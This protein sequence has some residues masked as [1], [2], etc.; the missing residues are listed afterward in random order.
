MKRLFEVEIRAFVAAENIDEAESVEIHRSGAEVY[1]VEIYD[2]K[3]IPP[4]WIDSIPFG[5]SEGK[6][7]RQLFPRKPEVKNE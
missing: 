4:Q 3:N 2:P 7:C 1:A 6:T 5:N